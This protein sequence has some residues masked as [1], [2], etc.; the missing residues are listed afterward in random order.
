[1]FRS[2]GWCRRLGRVGFMPE[3]YCERERKRSL[4]ADERAK[5]RKRG[6]MQAASRG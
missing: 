3:G 2:G 5:E 6:Q 1:M 4:S